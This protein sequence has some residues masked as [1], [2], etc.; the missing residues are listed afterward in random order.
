[1]NQSIM[2]SSGMSLTIPANSDPTLGQSNTPLER[3]Q[4]TSRWID[5]PC[6]KILDGQKPQ[7]KLVL[8]MHA[9]SLADIL[10]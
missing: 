6:V 7:R 5:Y 8:I 4:R 1:M 3:E 10:P 2:S 9:A